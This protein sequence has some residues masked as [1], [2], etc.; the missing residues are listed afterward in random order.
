MKGALRAVDLACHHMKVRQR[1]ELDTESLLAIGE[2]VHT[3]DRYPPY[4]PNREFRPF[5]FDDQALGAWVAEI[6][7]RVVGQV[8]L[9]RRTGAR[10]MRLAA[11]ALDSREDDLGVVARLLVAPES[12]RQGIGQT[13][14]ETAASEAAALGLHPMLDVATHL[15]A[16]IDLYERCGW[17]RTGEV[18]HEFPDGK[19]IAVFVYLAPPA[20]QPR[21]PRA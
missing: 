21:S 20:L 12:R 7:G 2:Q 10:A 17:L 4:L 5:L 16:A 11:E 13:L 1:C 8:A 6:D 14:L 15:E 9:H 18:L 19:T 3:S